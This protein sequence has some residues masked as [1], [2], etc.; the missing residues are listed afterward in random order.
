MKIAGFQKLTLIDYPG[1]IACTLFLHGCNFRCGFCHNPEL[2]ILPAEKTYS[3]EEVLEFLE[4]RRGQI[5]G[6][7]ITG[8]EP[9]ISVDKEFLRKIKDLGYPIKIDTNGCFPD[10]LKELV[11]EGLVDC[12]AMDIKGS[13]GKY[14]EITGVDVSHERIEESMRVIGELDNHEFRTTVV[15]WIHDAEEIREIGRWINEICRRKPR[16]YFLQGFK[17]YGKFI[18]ESYKMKNDVSE[19]YLRELKKEAEDYFEE[20]G[21]RV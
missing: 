20:V 12:V 16:R 11:S 7:C 9:L 17:N 18:D 4:K 1:K 15:E 21:V 19:S 8:G 10:R 14:S 6:V 2:V 5:E 3:E 13:R